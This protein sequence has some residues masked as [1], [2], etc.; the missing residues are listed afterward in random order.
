MVRLWKILIETADRGFALAPLDAV[1][2]YKKNGEVAIFVTDR[3]G[4]PVALLVST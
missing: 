4:E 1:A 3:E 2:E